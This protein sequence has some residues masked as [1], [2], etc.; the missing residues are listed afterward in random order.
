MQAAKGA[1]NIKDAPP[2]GWIERRDE[3]LTTING[4][5]Y[6]TSKAQGVVRDNRFYHADMD[7]TVAFPHGWIVENGHDS[8]TC[9]HAETTTR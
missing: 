4:I 2:G 9:V 8:I 3:Y 5:A 1:A 7:F 6:G